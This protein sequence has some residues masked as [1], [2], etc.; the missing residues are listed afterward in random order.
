MNGN[1][2]SPE[3]IG[4]ETVWEAVAKGNTI[5]W[6]I[7]NLEWNVYLLTYVIDLFDYTFQQHN[8]RL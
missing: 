8:K 2:Q 6:H 7:I 1:S 3:L 5:Y 4:T